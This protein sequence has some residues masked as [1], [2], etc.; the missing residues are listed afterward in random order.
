MSFTAELRPDSEQARGLETGNAL[1][2]TK[3]II[4]SG[5]MIKNLRINGTRMGI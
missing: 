5:P 4:L 1:G 3:P 2:Y